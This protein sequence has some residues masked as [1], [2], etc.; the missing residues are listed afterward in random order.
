MLQVR[1]GPGGFEPQTRG[2]LDMRTNH[3][4]KGMDPWPSG[5]AHDQSSMVGVSLRH[6]ILIVPELGGFPPST[7]DTVIVSVCLEPRV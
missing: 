7:A 2:L 4:T 1:E 6:M 3:L 5:Q